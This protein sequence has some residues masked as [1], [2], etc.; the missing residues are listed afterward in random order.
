MSLCLSVVFFCIVFHCNHRDA[1]R[2][3]SLN[4]YQHQHADTYLCQG[5]LQSVSSLCG[6]GPLFLSFVT[7]VPSLSWRMMVFHQKLVQKRRYSHLFVNTVCVVRLVVFQMEKDPQPTASETHPQ[8]RM[9]CV[10][11]SCQQT[12]VCPI[13]CCGNDFNIITGDTP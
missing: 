5:L 1:E 7:L 9:R 13:V 10:S 6:N 11:F 12:A 8:V 2:A 4:Q 3:L